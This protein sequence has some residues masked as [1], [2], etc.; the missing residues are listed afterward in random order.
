M[1]VVSDDEFSGQDQ[2]SDPGQRSD[3]IVQCLQESFA[4]LMQHAPDAFRTKFRKMARDPFAFYRGTACLFYADLGGHT[5]VDDEL[6]GSDERWWGEHGARIW[7]QGD[8]H[9]E[10][11]GTYMSGDGRLVFDV[12]DFDEAYVAPWTW[13][14]R[15]F[16]ASL[17]LICWGKALPDAVIDDLI[18]TYVRAYADEAKEFTDHDNIEWALTLDNAEGAVL[19]TLRTVKLVSREEF[20]GQVTVVEDYRRHFESTYGTPLD[21]DQR[22][23]LD[24]AFGTYQ[25]T[26]STERGSRIRF[27]VLDAVEL[28]ALGIGSAGLPAYS[29]LIEGETQALGNDVI[30]T[31][32][33]G[34]EAALE[35]VITDET[36][37][38]AFTDHGHRTAVSQRAL[39]D[40]TSPYLGWTEMNG[41]GFVVSEFSPYEA[42]LSWEDVT[43]PEDMRVLVRQL[44]QATAKI[45]CVADDESGHDLVDVS[46]EEV[47]TE[48]I[49]DDID[50]LVRQMTAFAHAYAAQVRTDHRLFVEAFRAGAFSEVDPTT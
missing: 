39:Q 25:D 35:R 11:F 10:N 1:G 45:H 43:E 37:G 46:V 22:K 44:G 13:E 2:R 12:N 48:A 15:R 31:M 7:I 5:K 17:A 6:T 9:V 27:D 32:K 38:S 50:E 40:H 18:D 42:D 34:Q 16:V 24:E 28:G 41:S 47:I 33:Q 21:D 36:I 23:A 49:G 20:L 29:V 8:L 30:I 26:L 14:I 4:E 3:E 19:D